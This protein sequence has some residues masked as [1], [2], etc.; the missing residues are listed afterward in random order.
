[1]FSFM[2]PRL[3]LF[4]GAG[5]LVAIGSFWAVNAWKGYVQS[6]RDGVVLEC[7]TT[8]LEEELAFE[9]QKVK[10]LQDR[11][12]LLQSII[13][14]FEPEVIERVEFRDRVITEI[15]EVEAEVSETEEGRLREEL[16]PSTRVFLDNL[17]GDE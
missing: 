15:R 14:N 5:V 16:S 2:S 10:D 1:M 8:Q 12:R 13:D 11:E 4:L 3:W 9:K 7:N 17:M 6:I